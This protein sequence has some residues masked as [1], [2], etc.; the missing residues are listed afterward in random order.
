LQDF[1]RRC[2]SLILLGNE[3][4]KIAELIF[5]WVKRSR[6]GTELDPGK[7]KEKR[8]LQKNHSVW[9]SDPIT[10]FTENRNRL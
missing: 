9:G 6:N 5:E 3:R 8:G 4:K 7:E 1:R 2:A 10:P